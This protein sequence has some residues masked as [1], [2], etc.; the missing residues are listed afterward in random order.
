MLDFGLQAPAADFGASANNG[1]GLWARPE[2]T[3]D[4]QSEAAVISGMKVKDFP[5]DEWLW[6]IVNN[7]GFCASVKIFDKFLWS[8]S[9][10]CC[11]V[12]H[13][14]QQLTGEHKAMFLFSCY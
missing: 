14:H 4:K 5:L 1:C 6:W 10:P 7:G 2:Q 13:T 8:I 12:I 3:A 9:C 11:P